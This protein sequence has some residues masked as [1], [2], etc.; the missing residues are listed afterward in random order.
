[1][2]LHADFAVETA[3]IRKLTTFSGALGDF[4][5][6]FFRIAVN[7]LNG[8]G[9]RAFCKASHQ[10]F[11]SNSA[12]FTCHVLPVR[13]KREDS[14]A[15]VVPGTA[16]LQNFPA[17]RHFYCDNFQEF[18]AKVYFFPS[19]HQYFSATLQTFT[20]KGQ[21]YGDN[22]R[23][24]AARVYLFPATLQLYSDKVQTFTA[25]VQ[26]VGAKVQNDGATVKNAVDRLYP[27]FSKRQIFTF[28]NQAVGAII[29]LFSCSF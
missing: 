2:A 28:C 16:A 11:P 9:N 5:A 1:M 13:A 19:T 15:N 20:A 18:A 8:T 12:F 25:K 7:L 23:N 17:T 22:L 27:L 26:I 24:F 29:Y 14:S 6:R 4:K 10:I 21:I 3:A